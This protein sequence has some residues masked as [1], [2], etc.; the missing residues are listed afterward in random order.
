MIKI[1]NLGEVILTLHVPGTLTT[2][3]N[4][5]CAYVPFPGWIKNVYAK[6]D[7]AGTGVTATTVDINLNAVSIHSSTAISLAAT[8]GVATHG[9]YSTDPTP[10]VAGDILSLDIDGI[11]VAPKNLC[12]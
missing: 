8:T 12:V 7:V 6:L 5:I 2:G 4:K 10:V 3:V 1:R 9:A 11:S